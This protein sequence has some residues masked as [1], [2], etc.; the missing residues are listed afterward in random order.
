M[1]L[2]NI[3]RDRMERLNDPLT[4]KSSEMPISI[5]SFISRFHYYR[6]SKHNEFD[7]VE[8]SGMRSIYRRETRKIS[9]EEEGITGRREGEE[10]GLLGMAG[11]LFLLHSFPSFSYPSSSP[12][13]RTP[14]SHSG[15]T[16]HDKL[17]G[18]RRA[19]EAHNLCHE[20]E[21]RIFL[22]LFLSFFF[23]NAI[24]MPA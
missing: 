14:S 11:I 16:G 12:P 24:P 8:D 4:P 23:F 9:D 17:V 6:S 18:I 21:K 22:F 19:E 7:L 2:Y 13:P 20:R 3:S 5:V 15:V 10:T 1:Q